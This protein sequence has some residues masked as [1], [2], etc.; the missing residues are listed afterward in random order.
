MEKLIQDQFGV[1][2]RKRVSAS[3][4]PA[5]LV[6]KVSSVADNWAVLA[7]NDTSSLQA[8]DAISSWVTQDVDDVSRVLTISQLQRSNKLI[9]DN[10]KKALLYHSVVQKCWDLSADSGQ[11]GSN[12]DS[13]NAIGMRRTLPSPAVSALLPVRQPL[14]ADVSSFVKSCR[15]YHQFNTSNIML[16]C[17]FVICFPFVDRLFGRRNGSWCSYN[18]EVTIL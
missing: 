12:S 10:R 8:Q 3:D 17:Q 11:G 16:L 7:R 18:T 15:K 4:L 13:M 2:D 5:N 6:S 1:G 14:I 9:Q